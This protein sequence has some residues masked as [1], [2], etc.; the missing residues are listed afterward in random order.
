[1]RRTATVFAGAILA[2]VLATSIQAQTTTDLGRGRGGSAHVK[3]E[4]VF[5]DAHVS[6]TYGRP[7][8]KG[9]PQAQMMPAGKPWRT[10][11]DAAT[12][13]TTDTPLRFGSVRLEPGSYTINTQPGEKSWE[14]IFGKLEKEGQWGVPYQP[15]LE[16]ARAPMRVSTLVAPVEELTFHIDRRAPGMVLRMDWGTLSASSP[17]TIAK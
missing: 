4:W 16:I 9:R 14:L 17:F 5:G 7:A 8:L 2:T 15:A 6:I 3:T 1:M 13:L 11:A 10:G 12:V